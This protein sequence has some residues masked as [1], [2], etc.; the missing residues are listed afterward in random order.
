MA[1]MRALF[2]AFAAG[3]LILASS[4]GASFADEADEANDVV[5]IDVRS[6]AEHDISNIDGDPLIPHTGIVAGVLQA[7]PDKS[8][9]IRLYCASGGRSGRAVNALREAGYLDIENAG[10]IND[11][12]RVRGL[13]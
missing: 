3:V 12:R 6:Q 5:W 1:F 8:T 7:Y 13:D 11:A 4:I 2:S 9:P 10:G